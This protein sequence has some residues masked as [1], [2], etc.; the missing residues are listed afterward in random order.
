MKGDVFMTSTKRMKKTVLLAILSVM[1][2]LAMMPA[3]AFADSATINGNT[4]TST[5]SITNPGTVIAGV[6]ET[7]QSTHTTD[8]S[9]DVHVDWSVTDGT[10]SATLSKHQGVLTPVTAGTVT[11]TAILR[12]GTAAS[13]SESAG[14]TCSGTQL[15]TASST[16]TIN[17]SSAYGFQGTGGNTMEMTSPNNITA[18]INYNGSNIIAGYN[19]IINTNMSL[20]SGACQFQFT[21][22]AGI[23]NFQQTH[24]E[25]YCLPYIYILD[26]YGNEVTGTN[27]SYTGFANRTITITATGLTAGNT[28]IIEFGPEVC[29]NNVDK[30]LGVPVD[31]QFNTI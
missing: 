18:G 25:T 29:G 19:N 23:N 2:V 8:Y 24:F 28:Y 10:G 6:Q 11:V 9:G 22:S 21:M 7:M 17:A 14:T 31:F 15:A 5:I 16:I 13:G 4:Y 20:S 3:M 30:K 26:K 12:T 1:M 27:V